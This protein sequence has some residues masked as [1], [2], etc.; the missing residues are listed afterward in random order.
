MRDPDEVRTQFNDRLNVTVVSSVAEGRIIRVQLVDPDPSDPFVPLDDASVGWVLRD[1]AG[2]EYTVN[3]VHKVNSDSENVIDVTGIAELPMPGAA[4]LRAPSLI[5]N[6]GAD[7]G[8]EVDF[9]EPEAFQRSSVRN[10]VQ[11]FDLKGS[12]KS[13]DIL[14]KISGYR[15][16]PSALWSLDGPPFPSALDPDRIYELPVG[17]GRFYTDVAPYRPMLD[18]VAADVVPLDVFC[19]ETSGTGSGGTWDPPPPAGLPAGTTLGKAIGFTMD[20]TSIAMTTDLGDGRWRIRVGPAADLSPIASIGQW[21]AVPVGM[22]DAKL[23]LETLPVETSPGVWEFEVLAGTAPTFGAAVDLAY[24]CRPTLGCGFCAASAIRIEVVPAEVLTDPDALL[25]G[26]LTRLVR[27]VLQVVPA[28]VRITDI[29][30]VVGPVQVPLDIRVVPATSLTATAYA[31]VGYHF[32][33]VPADEL[34]LDP[35]HV[36]VNGT[37]FTIP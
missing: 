33:L 21:H 12:E 36:V 6:L 2:R 13:Y 16:T 15:V 11:W 26:V 19:W 30:H 7:Y 1:A 28:H 32:D 23:Y 34:E 4:I 31:P 35:D 27:K 10:A 24:D 9:H 3:A 5:E 37:A 14:G 22:P 8:I 25:E 17:S 20:A 29:V 18:D